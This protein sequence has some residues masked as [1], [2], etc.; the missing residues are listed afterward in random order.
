MTVALVTGASRGI[1]AEVARELEVAGL[2]VV[3][4]VRTPDPT[5]P[6]QRRLDV[7]DQASIDDLAASLERLDVLVNNAGIVDDADDSAVGIDLDVVRRTLETNLFGAWRV[8]QACAPL[9]RRSGHGRI[10]NVSSGMGQLSDMTGGSAAYRISKVSLNALTRILAH[11]LAPDGVLVNA[12]SP[13]WVRSD[14]GGRSAPR[15]LEEGADTAVWLAT[16][17]DDGPTGGFFR[18]RRPN[19]W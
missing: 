9:L 12:V 18:D 14:M 3:R 16:L 13:G 2:D 15:S 5:D 8:A 7:T 19:P 4:G 10:V 6:T 1:G 11:E 17:P